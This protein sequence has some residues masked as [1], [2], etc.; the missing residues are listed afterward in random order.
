MLFNS[1]TNL[2]PFKSKNST[3]KM[4]ILNQ[5]VLLTSKIS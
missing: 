5:K 1:L 4:K 3:R 2:D